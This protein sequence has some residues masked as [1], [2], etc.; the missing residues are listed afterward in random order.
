[1]EPGLVD[2]VFDAL[3]FFMISDDV[4]IHPDIAIKQVEVMVFYLKGLPLEKREELVRYVEQV[5]L[6]EQRESGDS[7]RVDHLL[8]LD[9]YLGL[10]DQDVGTF[11]A[12]D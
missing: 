5:G 9:E 1:M 11:T 7:D 12:D 10:T 8:H 2:A 4:D 3:L 6:R